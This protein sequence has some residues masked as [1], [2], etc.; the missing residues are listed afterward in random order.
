MAELSIFRRRAPYTQSG[1][2]SVP[3]GC[4]FPLFLV[5]RGLPELPASRLKPPADIDLRVRFAAVVA[6][7]GGVGGFPGPFENG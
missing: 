7:V 1:I 2:L 6:R 3:T 5:G 4:R